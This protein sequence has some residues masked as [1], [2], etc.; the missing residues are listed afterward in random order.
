MLYK[1]IMW[2]YISEE[3][4]V[5]NHQINHNQTVLFGD[6]AS[7]ILFVAHG[8]SYN[9]AV[10]IKPFITKFCRVNVQ[11]FTPDNFMTNSK[12]IFL[13]EKYIIVGISQTGTSS[14]VLKALEDVNGK[15]EI[16]GI[17]SGKNSPIDKLAD[18]T[19][20][21]ECGEEDSNA[22]TKGYSSTLLQLMLLAL[23]NARSK[24]YISDDTYTSIM[25]DLKKE[26]SLIP[27]VKDK[28]IKW[29]EDNKLGVGMENEYVIGSGMNFG[30]ALE[31]Q[32]KMMETLRIP[33]MFNDIVEFSHG[34]HRSI[35]NKSYIV[36][37]NSG[38]E[39]KKDL[40]TKTFSYMR[41][42]AKSCILINLSDEADGHNVIN[43]PMFEYDESI[44][45]TTLVI[46]V[47]SAYV[48]EANNLDPNDCAND[49][50][51]D[52]VNTRV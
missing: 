11:V 3:E 43:I 1:S 45:L 10:A 37:I 42:I 14:G 30:T 38:D 16:Y 26:I 18:K 31:G 7:E 41:K 4:R 40:F 23:N 22:K 35:N 15:C 36:L 8:S 51:T 28:T 52:I 46:Q 39:F 25:N 6:D 50:Y 20:Y 32:L 12:Y 19:I 34:M 33:T 9:A 13:N 47:I 24:K 44:L 5:L 29:C 2:D 49:D 27:S 48:P 21:L 17:T